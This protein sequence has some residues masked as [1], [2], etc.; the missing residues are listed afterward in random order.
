MVAAKRNYMRTK[1]LLK[2]N[3]KQILLVFLAFFVMVLVSY[4]YVSNIVQQQIQSLGNTR[5]D[6]VQTSVAAS[7]SETEVIFSSIART[8]E[9]MLAV[10]ESNEGLLAYL[11]DTNTYFN[12]ASSP[13][14]GFM[15]V[16]GHFRGEWLDGSGWIP[17][18]DY[19]PQSRPWHAGAQKN[20]GR[21]YFSEPYLDAETGDMCISFSQEIF[22][23]S[24]NAQGILAVDLMLSRI[25]DHVQNQR[26]FGTGYGVLV[27]DKMTFIVHRDQGMVGMKMGSAGGDYPT[28]TN[29]LTRNE[30]ISAVRF[31]DAD[32][33]DC[34]IFFRTIFNGWYLGFIIPRAIYYGDVYSLA[35]TLMVLGFI[36]AIALSSLLIRMWV[37]KMRSDE[38]NSSKSNFL[39]HMSHEMRTP[40]NA[41][42]GMTNIARASDDVGKKEYCLAKINDA[43][44]HLLGVINDVLDMSKISAGK[45][46]LS[47]TNFAL[48]GMLRQVESVVNYKIEEKQKSFSIA[49]AQ[50]VPKALVA[51]R[52]RLAQV[53]TNLLSNADKF[54]SEGGHIVLRVRRLPDAEDGKCVLEFEVEDDGIGITKEQQTRLFRS[55]EQADGSISRK[56]GGTGLGLAISKRIVEMMGGGIRVESEPNV[57]TRFIFTIHALEGTAQ[58]ESD[59][60]S[61]QQS[62]VDD[63]TPIFAGRKILLAEDVAINR[64]ILATLLDGTGVQIENAE[65]G[66]RACAMFAASP[67]AY[68]MIFMDIQ[69]PEMDG[70]EATKNIRSMNAPKARAVP[71]V[72]MS[73]NVFREDIKKCREAGMDDHVGKPLEL[74]DIMAKMRHYLNRNN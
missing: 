27:D 54:T 39:A 24:G 50:N 47:E 63:S 43:S 4:S 72:A 26:I 31:R 62:E 67:E 68:D 6:S 30:Q 57:A 15:K 23:H 44:R 13:L 42:I 8:A 56:Y 10:G 36:L 28:L 40:M 33:A 29:M 71:I 25:T 48:E 3:F 60:M 21:I 65:N 37:Q 55:F 38:E 12:A 16:Y 59:E 1:E 5:M 52:Q 35:A 64:E 45:L 20:H 2:A 58:D 7:L 51:D 9:S 69:M 32:N 34:I 19:V 73:A 14:P 61:G 46:E 17:P 18:S 66:K 49:V 11:T 22:D 41:I 74:D 53:I 70:Y